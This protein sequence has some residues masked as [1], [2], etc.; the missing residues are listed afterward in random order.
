MGDNSL[1]MKVKNMYENQSANARSV[2]NDH[3]DKEYIRDQSHWRGYGRWKDDNRWKKIGSNS[4]YRLKLLE[5][6]LGRSRL[7]SG[8]KGNFLE[9][10][11]G[12]GTN[13]LALCNLAECYFGIDIAEENLAE[14]KRM[15]QSEDCSCSYNPILLQREPDEVYGSVNRRIDYFLS[16]AVFQH[17]PSKEY[18]ISVLKVI[19]E[20]CSSEAVG[21]IQIRYDN[22]NP[23]YS[24]LQET[25]N[26]YDRHL[27]ANSY[28]I[29][30]FY[31]I[32]K[33]LEFKEIFV[34]DINSSINY[35]TFFLAV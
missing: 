32:C 14:S 7:D 12:G 26:Y 28:A 34:K 9:W 3:M 11:P 8:T 31:D 25:E 4:L 15:I 17:F 33:S 16:T 1:N 23:K 2:W 18:G 29:D 27:T 22:G 24:S 10:G 19:R 35:C 30:E 20:L 5:R 6:Y 13:I 21:F